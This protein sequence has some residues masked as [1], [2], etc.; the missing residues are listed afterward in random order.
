MSLPRT[1]ESVCFDLLT[2]PTA[3][4]EMVMEELGGLKPGEVSTGVS[5]ALRTPLQL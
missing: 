5:W 3:H 1:P 2:A 4:M